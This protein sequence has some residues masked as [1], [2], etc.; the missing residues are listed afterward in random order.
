[1]D[2]KVCMFVW[3]HFT[4]DARVLRECTALS[5]NGYNVDLIC[6]HDPKADNMPYVEKRS[7]KFHIYR[8]KRY[9]ILLIWL[10]KFYSV[11]MKRKSIGGLCFLIWL[12]AAFFLP[13]IIIPITILSLLIL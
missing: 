12:V 9:P 11:C 7:E 10:Q 13:S 4:N 1:M 5:E 3:N 2:K 8:V 6:I